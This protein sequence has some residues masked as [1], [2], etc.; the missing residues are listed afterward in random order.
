VT[1]SIA[2]REE[3][4]DTVPEIELRNALSNRLRDWTLKGD[5]IER[6]FEFPSF[7]LAMDFVSKVACAAEEMNHHPDISINY[8]KVTMALTS[9]DSGGITRRD[10][11]L[12][13]K[14][15]EIA[16]ELMNPSKL[17]TA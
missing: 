6:R 17:K 2:A 9:H 11:R 1:A 4:M 12:A 3:M 13:G 7:K 5:M 8:N 15:D 10:L 16:P 14:M